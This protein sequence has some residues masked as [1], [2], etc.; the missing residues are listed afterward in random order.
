M[1]YFT[2][3]SVAYPEL[4]P[5]FISNLLCEVDA[6]VMFAANATSSLSGIDSD[7]IYSI[8]KGSTTPQFVEPLDCISNKLLF[9]NNQ[10][11][12][13][14]NSIIPGFQDVIVNSTSNVIV[15]ATINAI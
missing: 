10:I 6:M 15:V 7:I 13:L 1:N 14:V 11:S 12:V 9:I 5:F 3:Q 8:L 2:D 4:T